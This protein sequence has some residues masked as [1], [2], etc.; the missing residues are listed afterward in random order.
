MFAGTCDNIACVYHR[1]CGDQAPK[2]EPGPGGFGE[3][4]YCAL[5]IGCAGTKRFRITAR[6]RT[7]QKTR[8]IRGQHGMWLCFC[9]RRNAS[10]TMLWPLLP[11]ESLSQAVST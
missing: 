7:Q 8:A 6:T 5:H 11:T 10:D 4:K 3:L 9:G 1:V 2:Q